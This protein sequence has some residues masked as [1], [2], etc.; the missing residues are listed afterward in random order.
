MSTSYTNNQV[1]QDTI[2]S[3]GSDTIKTVATVL[4]TDVP[5]IRLCRGDTGEFDIFPAVAEGTTK[6]GLTL[7]ENVTSNY[8]P[9]Q[10]GSLYCRSALTVDSEGNDAQLV[11]ESGV[12]GDGHPYPANRIGNQ[13]SA[14]WSVH[15]ENGSKDTVMT[16][17]NSHTTTS[18]GNLWQVMQGRAGTVL[19]MFM[20]EFDVDD[21][22]QDTQQVNFRFATQA[23]YTGDWKTH[24]P[25]LTLIGPDDES[26][27]SSVNGRVTAGTYIRLSNEGTGE[28]SGDDHEEGD[29]WQN[30]TNVYCYVNGAKYTFDLTAV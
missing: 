17:S 16:L 13:A 19:K 15:E 4:S 28:A 20:Q 2:P 3:A 6:Y 11:H 26:L 9:L 1:P 30:E 7:Q 8:T 24:A 23:D 12:A 29:M 5:R 27:G 22:P 18:S 14:M 25:V 10:C 21:S